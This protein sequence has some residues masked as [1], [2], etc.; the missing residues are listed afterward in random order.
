MQVPCAVKSIWYV[1]SYA[2]MKSESNSLKTEPYNKIHKSLGASFS[3]FNVH[4][5]RLLWK[6]RINIFEIRDFRIISHLV[7]HTHMRRTSCIPISIFEQIVTLVHTKLHFNTLSIFSQRKNETTFHMMN[8]FL[9]KKR[10]RNHTERKRARE[11][12]WENNKKKTGRL[13]IQDLHLVHTC[14]MYLLL[15]FMPRKR[16]E[17]VCCVHMY[18]SFYEVPLHTFPFSFSPKVPFIECFVYVT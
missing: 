9:Q 1:V 10:F 2:I 4:F 17:I 14:E 3:L 13:W 5:F 15:S 11:R 6:G 7:S 18:I 12:E 8:F 16:L